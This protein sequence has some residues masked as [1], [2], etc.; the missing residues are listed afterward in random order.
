MSNMHPR[1]VEITC[2]GQLKLLAR[3]T[4]L[5]LNVCKSLQI[6]GDMLDG[7]EKLWSG[8]LPV[9]EYDL[10]R[11]GHLGKIHLVARA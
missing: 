2:S 4:S 7:K 10:R 3:E 9:R 11:E 5:Q 1:G 8:N 6:T